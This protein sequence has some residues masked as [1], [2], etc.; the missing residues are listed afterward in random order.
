MR[1]GF[2]GRSA[3]TDG[4][5]ADIWSPA[6]APAPCPLPPAAAAAAAVASALVH[7]L[8]AL[9]AV[10]PR[11]LAWFLPLM[12]NLLF[13]LACVG[14]LTTQRHAFATI[15]TIL[16]M[17]VLRRRR[18]LTRTH[19]HTHAERVHGWMARNRSGP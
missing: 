14:T 17:Y 10:P 12:L 16:N 8:N 11:K 5:R 13:R 7:T 9:T 15:L 4:A 19:A 6:S 2:E 18:L 3:T 1:R